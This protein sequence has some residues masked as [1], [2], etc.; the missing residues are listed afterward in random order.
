[1]QSPRWAGIDIG[2]AK[3]FR[4]RESYRIDAEVLTYSS[5]I[6]YFVENRP[7]D[8]QVMRGALLRERH[9]RPTSLLYSLDEELMDLFADKDL[10]VFE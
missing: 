10:V 6:T 4:G 1:L 9:P 7:N 8:A 2:F 3:W 5:V